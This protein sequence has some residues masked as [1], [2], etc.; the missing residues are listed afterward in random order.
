MAGI[1][2]A[3]GRNKP[4]RDPMRES[5]ALTTVYL[6]EQ[7]R[8]FEQ[9]MR[10]KVDELEVRV[11]AQQAR[12]STREETE[13][14]ELWEALESFETADTAS[15]EAAADELTAEFEPAEDL[16]TALEPDDEDTLESLNVDETEAMPDY[17]ALMR[18]DPADV[19]GDEPLAETETPTVPTPPVEGEADDI[20]AEDLSEDETMWPEA[21]EAFPVSLPE[22][23][24]TEE[25]WP[26]LET[27]EEI[28]LLGDEVLSAD[29]PDELSPD[30]VSSEEIPLTEDQ[31]VV[32]LPESEDDETGIEPAAEAEHADL[33]QTT[34][35]DEASDPN[36]EEPDEAWDSSLPGGEKGAWA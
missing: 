26:G 33:A 15:P 35:Q 24:L 6:L 7:N 30:Y 32:E 17:L 18:G 2:S 29:E 25:S 5:A 12:L 8:K 11:A 16:L 14:Q 13:E 4:K 28:D 23:D 21:Y 1:L 22:T 9:F 27:A 3:L 20:F 10:Q 36:G 34:F 31:L 19:E